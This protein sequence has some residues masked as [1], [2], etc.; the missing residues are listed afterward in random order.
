MWHLD[1][2]MRATDS[3]PRFS[4]SHDVDAIFNMWTQNMAVELCEVCFTSHFHMQLAFFRCEQI[5]RTEFASSQ[6]NSTFSHVFANCHIFHRWMKLPHVISHLHMWITRVHMW[7][8]VFAYRIP[9]CGKHGVKTPSECASA[10]SEAQKLL[11]VI[12]SHT[13][14]RQSQRLKFT[15]W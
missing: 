12:G 5:S 14:I 4:S 13:W 2:H 8:V 11:A 7:L 1:F 6:M 3:H 15:S 10:P 9:T